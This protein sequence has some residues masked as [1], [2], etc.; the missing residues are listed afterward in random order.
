V[1]RVKTVLCN[2]IR[3]CAVTEEI[4][5]CRINVGSESVV[6]L[7]AIEGFHLHLRVEAAQPGA[8]RSNCSG[9]IADRFTTPP[10]SIRLIQ[11]AGGK[12]RDTR[13]PAVISRVTDD[14]LPT[15]YRVVI[16][17]SRS[18]L[19][20]SR[21]DAKNSVLPSSDSAGCCSVAA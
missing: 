18:P 17:M 16:Q 10:M 14:S 2:A 21:S 12:T 11:R 13:S 20:P 6:V 3:F 1:S 4:R 7:L 9:R 5:Q 8:R 15:Y 19:P